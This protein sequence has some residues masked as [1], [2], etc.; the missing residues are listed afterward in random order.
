MFRAL[1][2]LGLLYLGSFRGP[3]R[4]K[5]AALGAWVGDVARRVHL[6]VQPRRAGQQEGR[7]AGS[8]AQE[9]PIEVNNK[10]RVYRGNNNNGRHNSGAV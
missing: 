1:N 6:H 8:R 4:Q 3:P 2:S 9:D 10:A 5:L 7:Q